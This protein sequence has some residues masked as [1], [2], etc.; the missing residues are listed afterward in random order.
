MAICVSRILCRLCR[1]KSCTIELYLATQKNYTL[2]RFFSKCSK[3]SFKNCFKSALSL[4][5]F[6]L[7]YKIRH[8][9]ISVF[10]LSLHSIR[11]NGEWNHNGIFTWMN[12]LFVFFVKE[13]VLFSYQQWNWRAALVSSRQIRSRDFLASDVL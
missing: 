10:K 12:V 3:R 4:G 5:P 13:N 6:Q 1:Y 11:K 7:L 8:C 9:I 2:W